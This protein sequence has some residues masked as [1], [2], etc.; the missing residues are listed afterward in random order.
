MSSA[1]TM[2]PPKYKCH[3]P[4]VIEAAVDE[5]KANK[6]CD[7]MHEPDNPHFSKERDK[8]IN[9]FFLL[10]FNHKQLN[11]NNSYILEL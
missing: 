6:L 1:S 7:H 2:A 4:K 10:S 8:V 11:G 3:D 5:V 9:M